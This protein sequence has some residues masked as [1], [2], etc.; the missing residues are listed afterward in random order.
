MH[1]RLVV[2]VEEHDYNSEDGEELSVVGDDQD[3]DLVMDGRHGIDSAIR[4]SREYVSENNP[5][6]G[7]LANLRLLA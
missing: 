7:T 5:R 1:D 3:L 2:G 6:E 4:L